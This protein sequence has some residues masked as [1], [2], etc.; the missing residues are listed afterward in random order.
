ML[1]RLASGAIQSNGNHG[2]RRPGRSAARPTRGGE[3]KA[4]SMSGWGGKAVWSTHQRLNMNNKI[5]YSHQFGDVLMMCARASC[6]GS[7]H[8]FASN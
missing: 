6:V 7:R 3:E 8:I 5:K 4:K 1:G 2:D